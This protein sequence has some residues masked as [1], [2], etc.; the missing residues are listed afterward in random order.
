MTV[1][2][3]AWSYAL[4]YVPAL[5]PFGVAAVAAAAYAAVVPRSHPFGRTLTAAAVAVGGRL[6]KPAV[7]L[8]AAL[9]L[10]AAFRTGDAAPAAILGGTGGRLLGRGWVA[11]AAAV[12][13]VGTFFCGSTALSNLTLAPVQAAAAAA[14]GVPLTHVLALQAVGAAAGNSISLAILI[15]A[16][17][18]VGGLRPDVLAVPEGV[19]LRRSAGPWAA[20]VALSSA[21]GCALF[22]TSAWP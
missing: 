1:P 16:K 21:A 13:S 9:I 10:A 12:G 20:F 3:V 18:V 22:L 17:A 14:A 6:A 8:V 5:V 19:L 2:G 11:V 7:A 15:N 4:L